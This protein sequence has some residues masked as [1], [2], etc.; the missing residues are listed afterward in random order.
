LCGYVFRGDVAAPLSGSATFEQI[1]RE[2]AHVRPDAFRIDFLH[3]REGGTWQVRRISRR[4]GVFVRR[5][6]RGNVE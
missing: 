6:R 2:V 4:P 3:R 1:M 5:L